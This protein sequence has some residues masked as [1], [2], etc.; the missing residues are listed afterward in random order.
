MKSI[1]KKDE[2]DISLDNEGGLSTRR[3]FKSVERPILTNQRHSRG[4]DTR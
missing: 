1:S 3:V 4:G 2:T